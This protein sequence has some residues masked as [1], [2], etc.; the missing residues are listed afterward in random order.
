VTAVEP[1]DQ[2]AAPA[3]A[4][5]LAEPVAPAPSAVPRTGPVSGAPVPATAP[6]PGATPAPGAL[7]VFTPGAARP[8]DRPGRTSRGGRSAAALTALLTAL[9]TGLITLLGVC[10]LPLRWGAFP[11]PVSALVVAAALVVLPRTGYRVTGSIGVASVPAVV[12]FVVTVVLT[13]HRNALWPALP[14]VIL[15]WRIL[16]FLGLGGLATALT[17][18]ALANP[19]RRP[20]TTR[21]V[22][23]PDSDAG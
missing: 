22:E 13:S 1:A 3:R 21:M 9:I 4:S 16:L 6:V 23:P 20:A 12:W 8:V 10:F 17:L 5:D 2:D 19:P 18:G 7:P 15:D 11:F 14:V